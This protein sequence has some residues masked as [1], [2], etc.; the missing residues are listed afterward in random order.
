MWALSPGLLVGFIAGLDFL[1]IS[2]CCG[3][4]II[5]FWGMWVVWLWV[6]VF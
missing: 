6:L 3:F 5:Q 4:D 2:E 1:V